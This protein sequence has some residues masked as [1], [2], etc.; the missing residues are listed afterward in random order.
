MKPVLVVQGVDSVDEVPGLAQLNDQAEIRCATSVDELRAALPG[1]EALLGWNFRA[2]S[3]REAW[4]SAADLRW[5][6]WGGAGVDAAMFDELADSDVLLTN[7]RGVFDGAMAEWVLGMIICFAKRIPETLEY[8]SRCEWNYRLSETV[9]GKR[10]LVVGV[11]SIGRAIGRLLRA[12]GMQV[13]AI[14]RSARDGEPDFSRIHAISDLHRH[15]EKS[16]YVVL[17]TPL[18]PQTRNLFGSAEFGAMPAHARFINVGRGALVDEEALLKALHEGQIGGAALD[19][20]VEE[21]LPAESPLWKAPNCLISPH[22]S[23]DFAEY[24][25]VM[26]DQFLDNWARFLADEPLNNLVDKQLGFV[27]A[28]N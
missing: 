5:I 6:H 27:P 13:E 22:M 11:G 10:A 25:T 3:L 1:A 12:A 16:D 18:T 28:G 14:G 2:D 23:G 15:L 9:A 17:I 7:A 8:Q 4:D 21:P 20:F 24:Q 26:A 19:V